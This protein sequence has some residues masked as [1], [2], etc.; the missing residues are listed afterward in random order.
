MLYAITIRQTDPNLASPPPPVATN[1]N[2]HW[3]LVS[4][5][6]TITNS[7]NGLNRV[8][9]STDTLN[10]TRSIGYDPRGNIT[11]LGGQNF[12]YDTSDQPTSIS[13]AASGNYL[14]DGNMKRVRSVVNGKT[15]YNVYALEQVGQRPNNQSVGLIISGKGHGSGSGTLTH[16]D[17]VTD[18]KK[19]DYISKVARISNG[20]ITYLHPDHLGSAVSGTTSTGAMAWA[21]RY[22]PFGETMLSPTANDNL[23]GY[24]GHI[25][26]AATGLNYMQA[27][28][29]DPALGRFLSID[30]VGFS[31]DMPFMFGRYTYVGNDPVNMWDPFGEVAVSVGADVRVS[32]AGFGVSF[33]V[34]RAASISKN[35][36]GGLTF[37]KGTL[38][39]GAFSVAGFSA[40]ASHKSTSE[41]VQEFLVNLVL[42][43]GVS[44][45]VD[46]GISIGTDENPAD[47]AD[48]AG[49]VNKVG[50]SAGQGVIVDAEFSSSDDN[51]IK[52]LELGVGVGAGVVPVNTAQERQG[53]ILF[54]FQE[55][56]TEKEE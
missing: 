28:Y 35:A 18:N 21:E 8:T 16:V 55:F 9:Q 15:I 44:G 19:T 2:Y 43:T 31:P 30:P 12:T 41:K 32:V 11:S 14:Y 47:V 46:V 52:T 5:T 56:R 29:Y 36:E 27:R 20:V 33:S 26:D 40:L 53:S 39:S 37:Q 3:R 25:K 38:L 42:D 49:P 7:Y 6:I 24:T 4:R 54:D 17:A 23:D 1:D 34:R 48:L 10:G 50:I 22:T 45:D 13:G 51:E